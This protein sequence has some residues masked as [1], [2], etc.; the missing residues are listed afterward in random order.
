VAE[1]EGTNRG[2]FLTLSTIGLGAMIGGVIG[3]PA[4][5]YVL[6]PVL[7]ETTFDPV[8]LGDVA[9]FNTEK[10][11]APTAATYIEDNKQPDTSPGLAYVHFT[12]K[13]GTTWDADDAMFIVFSNRCMHLGCP[14]AAIPS[15]GFQCPCHGGAYN[16]TGARVAG[17]PIRPLDRFAWQIRNKNEL[18]ITQRWSVDF[19]SD[20][21][22][23]YYQ[24]KS[25]GQPV[26]LPVLGETGANV[27]YPRVTYKYPSS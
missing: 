20:G 2:Q 23:H 8:F 27:L 15:V 13:S 5:A 18:W 3:V 25:P 14:I 7:H 11:F 17:P 26:T 10:G 6:A 19:N 1:T 12:G 24:V 4:T 22:I 21:Q 16:T 9:S